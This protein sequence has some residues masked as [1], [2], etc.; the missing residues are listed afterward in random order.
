MWVLN[1]Y[2]RFY[3]SLNRAFK[4][5]ISKNG[6]SKYTSEAVSSFSQ[7][8]FKYHEALN[9]KLTQRKYYTTQADNDGLVVPL[10]LV[11]GDTTS[12]KDAPQL[13]QTDS[14]VSYSFKTSLS[15]TWPFHSICFQSKLKRLFKTYT[16]SIE[17]SKTGSVFIYLS[18]SFHSC[19]GNFHCCRRVKEEVKFKRRNLCNTSVLSKDDNKSFTESMLHIVE[20]NT[21]E[22][23]PPLRLQRYRA[24]KSLKTSKSK[25]SKR[26]Q[27][28]L[29][30]LF[31]EDGELL[32]TITVEKQLLGLMQMWA[33]EE[34]VDLLKESVED[35]IN[36]DRTVILNLLQ[37]LANLGEVE[38]LLELHEF[39]KDCGLSTNLKFYH[40]LRDAY[41][42]SGRVED[43][44][45]MLR[46][47]YHGSRDFED[48]DLLFTL[49][50]TMTAKHFEH[51]LSVVESYVTDL[52]ESDPPVTSAR[53]SLWRCLVLAEKFEKADTLLEQFPEVKKMVP[54]QVSKLVQSQLEV[55]YDR[56]KVLIWLINS[57][58]VKPGLAASLFDLLILH[59]T[60]QGQWNEGLKHLSSAMGEGRKIHRKTV[61]SFLAKFFNQLPQDQVQELSKW[62]SGLQNSLSD[63]ENYKTNS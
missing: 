54:A 52:E 22:K 29:P 30:H 56:D 55:D 57:P 2:F 19:N 23:R 51:M 3:S 40:C 5:N 9:G 26:I 36:P 24:L 13:L 43:G 39:L 38:C 48:T 31:S 18:N 45:L 17:M 58:Y 44:I 32:P 12:R 14:C 28:I 53:A 1:G 60:A 37:Q 16:N 41:F 61:E 21:N 15:Q 25:T 42:N 62:A 33:M 63:Y 7:V 27:R 10:F 46:V 20:G 59:K 50:A 6:K 34:A 8:C 35:G 49:L 4:M 11:N 47:I